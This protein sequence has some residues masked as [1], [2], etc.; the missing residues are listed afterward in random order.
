MTR[1]LLF[2]AAALA[3]LARLTV[4]A[5]GDALTNA[6]CL[7]VFGLCGVGWIASTILA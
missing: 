1:T 2:V 6:I 3:L 5:H 4:Y 7:A